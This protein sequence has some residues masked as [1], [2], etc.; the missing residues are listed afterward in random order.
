MT[1]SA[2]WCVTG[3]SVSVV[4]A[5][6]KVGFLPWAKPQCEMDRLRSN[7][8]P[9]T[10]GRHRGT[11]MDSPNLQRRLKESRLA[12]LTPPKGRIYVVDSHGRSPTPAA[13]TLSH[14]SSEI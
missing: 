6:Y 7:S 10:G 2:L 11:S 14:G 5:A 12:T 9:Q 3:I 8:T 13:A 1:V 4:A